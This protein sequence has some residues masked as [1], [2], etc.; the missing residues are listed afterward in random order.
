MT[1]PVGVGS[2]LTV[3]HPAGASGGI[4]TVEVVDPLVLTGDNYLVSFYDTILIAAI[5]DTL[6]PPETTFVDAV[7]W[8]LENTTDGVTLLE[9]QFNQ[10]ADDDYEVTEGFVVRVSGPPPGFGSFEV[11]A[12]GNGVIDPPEAGAFDFDGF[13]VPTD[14]DGTPLRPT[15]NQQVGDGLW[16]F[17]TADN[18]GTCDG[19]T[20]GTYDAFISRGTRDGANDPYILPYDF[21]MRFTG[22][23]SNPGVGGSYAIEW[24][25]DD[26]VFWVPFELWRTGIGTPNDPSDDVRLVPYI[27]DDAGY[28]FVGDDMYALESWGCFIDTIPGDTLT[29]S[30][31]DGEHSASGADNDPWT[32]WVYWELPVDQTP[33][34]AGYQAAEASMLAATFDGSL[35]EHEII[36]RTV[37]VNWNGHTSVDDTLTFPPVFTQDVP[38]QGTIFRLVTEKP[39][40]PADTFTFATPAPQAAAKNQEALERIT[41]VPNPFYLFSSYDPNPGIKTLKFHH[42]PEKCTISIYNLGGTLVRTIEKD[43]A[44]T[45]IASWDLLTERRLPVASGIY[46]YV[47]D[48]PG[49]GQKI[50]KIAVLVESEVLQLY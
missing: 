21:E 45:S 12:N 26:N 46:I 44:S 25:N 4:V 31:G 16:G 13:P 10:S 49:F 30:G 19:G 15:A 1:L 33:G 39:N 23:N 20:R 7:Y 11:V 18:G 50:G 14:I 40:A 29:R 47:V 9:K 2:D 32:D 42:L 34:D 41:A 38:E 36:A 5:D 48:A 24:F 43:D 35:V 22:D 27:I 17:H 6:I 8:N 28:G 37:L 3:A